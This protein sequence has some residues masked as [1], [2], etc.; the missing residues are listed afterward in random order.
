M[1]R[2]FKTRDHPEAGGRQAE[3]GEQAWDFH[4]TL[5]DGSV[6]HVHMGREARDNFRNF[7]L[8]EEM[9]DFVDAAI[10]QL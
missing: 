6:L 2:H 5:E 7:V 9:D 8:R 4:W 3:P 10:G 1:E